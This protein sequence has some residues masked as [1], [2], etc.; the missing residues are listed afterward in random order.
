MHAIFAETSYV[1][2][3]FGSSKLEY[4]VSIFILATDMRLL[5]A[6]TRRD[7]ELAMEVNP[8][9]VEEETPIIGFLRREDYHVARAARRLALYWKYR[10]ELFGDR[11][12]VCFFGC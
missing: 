4:V 2:L 8:E 3:A 6:S 10:H 12:C 11:W 7:Y 9:L 5:D 1:F